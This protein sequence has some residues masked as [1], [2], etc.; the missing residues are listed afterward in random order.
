MEKK[1]KTEVGAE[2]GEGVKKNPQQVW[3][4]VWS[5]LQPRPSQLCCRV[6]HSFSS[7]ISMGKKGK[8]EVGIEDGKYVK[9]NPQRIWPYFLGMLFNSFP[10]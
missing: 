8:T 2:V 4:Y 3:P 7:T 9:E 5:R 1:E 10:N 6:L